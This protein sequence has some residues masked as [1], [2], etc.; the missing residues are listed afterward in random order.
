[1]QQMVPGDVPRVAAPLVAQEVAVLRDQRVDALVA[2]YG[3][4]LR[5]EWR[6]YPWNI[7]WNHLL[8]YCLLPEAGSFAPGEQAPRSGASASADPVSGMRTDVA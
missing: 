3:D 6:R 5:D 7:P 8:H 1:M 2:Q 4:F